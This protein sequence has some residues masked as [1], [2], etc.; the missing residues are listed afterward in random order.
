[1]TSPG[2]LRR[3]LVGVLL[4]LAAIR[5]RADEGMWMPHQIPSLAPLFAA[6]GTAVD[7]SA[8]SDPQGPVLGAVGAV[9]GCTVSFVSSSG[10]L[11]T[12]HHCVEPT[13]QFHSRP[14]ANLVDSGFRARTPADE[15]PAAP[16]ARLL[17]TTAIRDVTDAILGGLDPRLA[18]PAHWTEIDRR[19]KER[20]SLCERSGDR[21]Q[22]LPF[23]EGSRYFEIVQTEYPDVRLVW[24][25]P[26]TVGAFGGDQDN[27]R[28]PRH[29]GDFALYRVYSAPDGRPAA[30]SPSNVP[31]RP[32]HWLRLD[33]DGAAPGERVFV[34]GY[35][36]TTYRMSTH[37]DTR[38]WIEWYF[39]RNIRRAD[40]LI[41]ILDRVS[42]LGEEHRIRA[43]GRRPGLA[44]SRAKLQSIVDGFRQGRQMERRA[45]RDRDLRAWVAG[46]PRRDSLHGRALARLDS[47]QALRDGTRERDALLSDLFRFGG[48]IATTAD[49]LWMLVQ[50]RPKPDADRDAA[51]QERNWP[52]LRDEQ[53]RLQKSW[54]IPIERGFLG[55]L[56]AEAAALPPDQRLHALDSMTGNIPSTPPALARARAQAL[57]DSLV[58]ST[59]LGDL[60]FRL[61]VF[62]GDSSAVATFL[63]DP[64][65]AFLRPLESLALANRERDRSI[66][67]ELQRTT[68]S[69]ARALLERQGGLVAPDAN[70]TLRVA[71][72]T[73]RGRT[74]PDGAEGPPR[75]TLRGLA[76]RARDTSSHPAPRRLLDA[77][78]ARRPS[79]WT[80]SVL[81]DV[82]VDFLTTVDAT[83]GNSGSPT[84]DARG[85]VVGVLFD[86]LYESN[87]SIHEYDA[88]LNRSIH[89][90]IRYLLW[91]LSEVDAAG[92]LL[93]ELGIDLPSSRRK[94]GR[95]R[96]MAR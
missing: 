19:V 28:W 7:L 23:W 73:V 31:L 14:G 68:P 51:F 4:A 63:A 93:Q 34:A 72:G 67:G 96:P 78:A 60:D 56:L 6:S 58:A 47:L 26:L 85:R 49:K 3:P 15:L 45:A 43:L 54:D 17:V 42:A 95:K 13:L 90:D 5:A 55:W 1:M 21:C 74:L 64:F 40:S 30:R 52:R 76:E 88:D 50:E 69:Y 86:G 27:W 38:T 87:A 84:L 77:I 89:V 18:A 66:D 36:G 32:R 70:G 83:S 46:S 41:A 10:L 91:T 35:P 59:R 29:A 22:V 61:A 48:T 39:P 24:A 25:P 80:D 20:T 62:D 8:F 94:P 81:K 79:P 11:L 33:P 75:T 92:D 71:H 57:A 82:P 16:G 44:N 9:S 65:V 2:V 53:I 12:N 37:H